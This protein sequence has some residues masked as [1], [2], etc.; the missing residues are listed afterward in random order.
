MLT[1]KTTSFLIVVLLI[2]CFVGCGKQYVVTQNV[3]EFISNVSICSVGGFTDDLPSDF[4]AENKPTMEEIEKFRDIIVEELGKV[5]IFRYV[6][7]NSISSQY[8][9]SGSIL[10]F[11]KGSGFLRFLIGFGVGSAKLTVAM[12]LTDKKTNRIIFSGNFSRTISDWTTSGDDKYKYIARD[13]AKELKKQ[14][15]KIRE[16]EADSKETD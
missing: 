1:K 9:V 10:D 3:D 15:K 6:E 11:K 8:E 12:D 2:F 4:P 13:F 5:E 14:L 7:I 16:A